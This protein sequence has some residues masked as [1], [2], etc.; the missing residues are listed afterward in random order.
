MVL[1]PRQYEIA[2]LIA[3]GHTQADIALMLGISLRTVEHHTARIRQKV[4][5]RSTRRAVTRARA[6]ARVARTTA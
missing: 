4:G 3:H 6:G 2:R 5:E 1:S